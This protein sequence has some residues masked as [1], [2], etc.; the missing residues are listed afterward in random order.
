[1]NMH[2]LSRRQLA[3]G[4]RLG[5]FL[6]DARQITSIFSYLPFHSHF[7][8][9]KLESWKNQVTFLNH[10]ETGD[11]AWLKL[12]AP[13]LPRPVDSPAVKPDDNTGNRS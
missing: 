8:D 9:G 12:Q 2:L 3:S 10:I 13:P 6:L 7:T 5:W 11:R 4:S 1:M